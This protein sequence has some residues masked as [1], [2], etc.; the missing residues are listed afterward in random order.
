MITP[1]ARPNLTQPSPPQTHT[2]THTAGLQRY[3][4][5]GTITHSP[6]GTYKKLL[7]MKS[8]PKNEVDV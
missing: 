7:N 2:D 8:N 3:R 5:R 1:L 4:T 6:L